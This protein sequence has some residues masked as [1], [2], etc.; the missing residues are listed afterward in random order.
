[1]GLVFVRRIVFKHVMDWQQDRGAAVG[2]L[3]VVRFPDMEA[4][5][6]R[7][8]GMAAAARWAAVARSAGGRDPVVVID[9]AVRGWSRAT[10]DDFDRAGVPYPAA[11]VAGTA[12][13]AVLAEQPVGPLLLA[14]GRYL[15]EAL[16]ALL[17]APRA[18][19]APGGAPATAVGITRAPLPAL[20]GVAP[21]VPAIDLAQP[22]RAIRGLLR[23][24][25]KPS[26]G[27]VS[28]WLNR[29]VSQRISA[30]LLRALPGIRP[31][32]ITLLVAAVA[33]AMIAA[34][35][36]GGQA[37]LVAG[38]ILFQLASVLD[39]VDGEIARTSYRSSVAG[40]ILDTRVDVVTN[41]G[42]F[43]GIAIGLTRLYGA[44]QAIV[45]GVVVVVAVAGMLLLSG[46]ARRAGQ[47]GSL[48]VV[49]DY[50]RR[51]FPSGWQHAVTETLVAMTS[52]D[53]FAFAF[54]VIVVAGWGWTVSWLLAGFSLIWL[55]TIVAAI[56]GL[57]YG[58]EALPPYAEEAPVPARVEALAGV[59]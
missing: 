46:L 38:A 57:L 24:T 34:L 18:T 2:T 35:L 19:R 33:V 27:L 25:V 1:M 31:S 36:F 43:V 42:F 4:A 21:V 58:A 41:L 5:E 39:G 29:P 32:H 52:R 14:V 44:T 56:P 8:A 28:R 49:K 30:D 47:P 26:D 40:A 3:L 53:F 7:L 23:G 9:G 12:I 17:A 48:N 16:E 20:G 10:L 37:G 45:G 55:V 11:P 6:G 50:Y 54:C 15:P 51:R 59:D 22:A 13:A